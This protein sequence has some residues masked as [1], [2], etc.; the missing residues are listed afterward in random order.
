MRSFLVG[1][2]L[3]RARIRTV[4]DMERRAELEVNGRVHH[5]RT[6]SEL[7]RSRSAPTRSESSC[8]SREGQARRRSADCRAGNQMPRSMALLSY[9]WVNSGRGVRVCGR[10]G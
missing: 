1:L 5:A 3:D 4:P 7:G 2:A 8:V 9:P 6:K 10:R